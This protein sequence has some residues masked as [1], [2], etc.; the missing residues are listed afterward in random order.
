MNKFFYKKGDTRNDVSQDTW[1]F[2]KIAQILWDLFAKISENKLWDILIYGAS[3]VF[4]ILGITLPETINSWTAIIATIFWLLTTWMFIFSLKSWTRW[5]DAL[6]F[7]DKFSEVSKSLSGWDT[8]WVLSKM[9]IALAFI[10]VIIFMFFISNQIGT[11]ISSVMSWVQSTFT[12]SAVSWASIMEN[13]KSA[14]W[15]ITQAALTM[16]L[17]YLYLFAVW[18]SL[19]FALK[20][21][22]TIESES[23]TILNLSIALM[24]ITATLIWSYS[25]ISPQLEEF[26][27]PDSV[28]I[29]NEFNLDN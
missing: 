9:L 23:A 8:G 26:W 4:I 17:F 14:V 5:D 29:W 13:L 10:W 24:L 25:I 3:L 12:D 7:N 28:K 21:I 18:F 27:T 6:S 2:W 22:W 11:F 16:W 20:S 15:F 19:W 1:V